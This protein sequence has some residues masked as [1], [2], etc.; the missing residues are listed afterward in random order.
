[1]LKF[2]SSGNFTFVKVAQN[3]LNSGAS[4]SALGCLS[5]L[6]LAKTNP[7]HQF[8][9][10]YIR[11][12]LH[13][14]LHANEALKELE[15]LGFITKHCYPAGEKNVFHWEVECDSFHQN[16]D[17][18]G[19]I[20]HGAGGEKSTGSNL[21]LL[22][23]LPSSE[24][25]L[26]V[27]KDVVL[28]Q[29][30]S[31]SAKGLYLHLF[32]F[33]QQKSTL[34]TKESIKNF[35]SMSTYEFNKA[36]KELSGEG[37]LRIEKTKDRKYLFMISPRPLLVE[38]EGNAKASDNKRIYFKINKSISSKT[39]DER[40]IT[41]DSKEKLLTALA[42]ENVSF[43]NT[44]SV[45]FTDQRNE[46]CEEL[47]RQ[48][49]RFFGNTINQRPDYVKIIAR[50]NVLCDALC[51]KKDIKDLS[52]YVYT[53]IEK[54]FRDLKM[55]LHLSFSEYELKALKEALEGRKKTTYE[56]KSYPS[57]I[58]YYQTPEYKKASGCQYDF[59]ALEA[60]IRQ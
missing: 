10:K 23:K 6:E 53:C 41:I 50:Y 21:R 47:N 18:Y 22:K 30:L 7:N 9:M 5:C 45:L 46:R 14:Y 48:L 19:I 31:L 36:W 39:D 13:S 26:R 58:S 37:F 42:D 52:A 57:W 38:N 32:H 2:E 54:S 55:R 44:E 24:K 20:Y 49:I 3:A 16:A 43:T 34:S 33:S 40:K 8:S 11:T 15:R 28:N 17:P 25:F 1:M 27:P 51:K 29:N 35:V 59:A 4:A 60:F 56:K 12:I